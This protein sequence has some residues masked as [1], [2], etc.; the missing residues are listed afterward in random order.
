[1]WATRRRRHRALVIGSSVVEI[2]SASFVLS[3][4]LS[5][6]TLFLRSMY[7]MREILCVEMEYIKN[8][9]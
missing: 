9:E 3:E 8:E 7:P 1:V 4:F 2:R 5:I 6:V